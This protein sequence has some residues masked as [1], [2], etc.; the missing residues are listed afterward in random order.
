MA[1]VLAGGEG[2]ALSHRS[3]AALWQ[4]LPTRSA[5][6]IAT[7]RD[8]RNRDGIQFH[9]LV[10]Q[11]DEVAIHDGIPTGVTQLIDRYPRRPGAK[12]LARLADAPLMGVTR[13]EL[14]HS[15]HALVEK[16]DLPRP[17]RNQP[18]KI[19]ERTFYPDAMWPAADL[20]VEL[21]SRAAHDT[22]SRFDSDRERDRLFALA[23]FRV[24][25][26][27]ARHIA[28]NGGQVAADLRALIA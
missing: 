21:D 20:V 1:A 2:A 14:E 11:F 8:L 28:T 3:A 23:G 22:S 27:T 26:L 24:I 6:H 18:L 10:M 25:R 16:F 5:I 15:F 13:E 17:L 4:L 12:A 9:S 19:G 7:P